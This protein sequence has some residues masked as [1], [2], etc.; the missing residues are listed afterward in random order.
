MQTNFNQRARAVCLGAFCKLLVKLYL[1]LFCSLTFALGTETGLSQ[2]AKIAITSE[3]SISVKQVFRLIHKQTGYKFI[4]SNAYLKDAP[5]V[6]LNKG[7]IKTKDLLDNC[8]SPLNLDFE[9]TDSQTIVVQRKKPVAQ[10]VNSDTKRDQ[11]TISGMVT[12]ADGAPLPGAN[13]IEKGTTNGTQTDFDGNFTLNVSDAQAVIIVS[14]IG[15]ATK[16]IPLNGSTSVSVSLEEDAAGLEEVVVVA[17]GTVKKSDLT[18]AV[19]SIK[20]DEI[21]A[22]PSARLDDALRG[23]VSGVQITPTSSQPGAAASI[24]IR[25]TNSITGNSSPL[26]VI[27]G[28]IGAGNS[29]DINVQDI[30][31]VE[32]LKD[33]SATALYGSR[34]SAGV[35]LITTKRGKAGQSRFTYDAYT[36]FQSPTRFIDVLNASE[37]ADWQNEVQGTEAY[38]DPSSYG[39]G[40]NWQEEIYRNGAPMTSHTLSASGGNE[41]AQYFVSGNYFNQEGV[42]TGGNLKRYQFRVNGDYK[43]NK[44]LKVGNSVTLSRSTTVPRSSNII[45]I[46]GWF[47]TLPVKDENGEYT[48]QTASAELSAENPVGAAAKNVNLDTRT[49]ILG[50]IYAELEPLKNLRYKINYGT[51]LSLDKSEDYAPSTLFSQANDRGTATIANSEYLSVLLEQTLTYSQTLGEHSFDGLLGYTRQRIFNSGSS[52]QTRGFTT[53][54]FTYNNIDAGSERTGASSFANEFGVESF[55]FRLNYAYKGKYRVTLNGRVDGSSNFAKDS[56]WGTFPSVAVAWNAGREKFIENL[57]LFDDLK[58]RASYG[59]LGNPASGG[60][61]LARL[62]AGFTYLFGNSGD[63]TNGIGLNRLGN[64]QLKFETT[65]QLDLGLDTS[66]F[67]DRLQVTLDYYHKK[68]KDLFTDQ[69]ILWITGVPTAIIP[70]NFGTIENSGFELFVNSINVDKGD[71]RWDTS[72]NISTN[73]NK[74]VSIPD[75]DGELL[76]NRIGGVVNI[77]SAV[78]KEGEPLGAFYGYIR[79]GIWNSQEEIDASGLEGRGVFPGGKRFRDISGP[80]G[81]PDGIIDNNDQTV[82]GSPHPD[83]FGGMDNTITYKNFEFSMYWSF[84]LGNDIF[85]ET[86]AWLN[87]AFDNNVSARFADRWTPTNTETSVPSARGV[88]RTELVPETGIIEDGSFLR[89]RNLSLGYNIPSDKLPIFQSAKVYVRGTNLL[90]FDNYSGYDPEINRGDE[91][92]R[93]GYD[94]AQDPAVRSYT[95]GLSLTF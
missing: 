57:S 32:V 79:D 42:F 89:L 47:P 13:I 49:R 11:F 31:S 72:F 14:Y 26:F 55:L 24:R 40:T 54:Y 22:T 36:T 19:S 92:A 43:L 17:Y 87:T 23:K 1:I 68:T 61:S 9:F 28:L 50:T 8:L 2:D 33:A 67:N 63:I 86:D 38:P 62:G 71:F 69:E 90:L 10:R 3:K 70:T 93:R 53:D 12:D 45:N 48:I 81:V 65:D 41:K 78:I 6:T 30:E 37:F 25:G 66:F 35:V 75:E 7:V 5:Y 95:L 94:Q 74:V 88:F 64:D 73:K 18:G 44:I 16:E 77:P 15:F 51:D 39:E 91:N 84:V 83:L 82:I 46:A 85:N 34:G 21:N 76:I 56:K 27:D 58:F 59:R 4:F 20:T 80:D 52:V 60:T 29:A